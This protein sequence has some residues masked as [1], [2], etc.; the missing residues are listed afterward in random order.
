MQNA[1]MYQPKA[2]SLSVM[3][4]SQTAIIPLAGG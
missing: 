3:C 2:T 4:L 1:V